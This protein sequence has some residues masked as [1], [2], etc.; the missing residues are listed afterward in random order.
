MACGSCAPQ[1]L[2][3]DEDEA[4]PA[5]HDRPAASAS[6][7]VT[8]LVANYGPEYTEDYRVAEVQHPLMG[9]RTGQEQDGLAGQ[10][11]PKTL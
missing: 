5:Q 6:G 10:R 3:S 1:A 2:G 4:P 11:D 9:Q 7:P 8:K